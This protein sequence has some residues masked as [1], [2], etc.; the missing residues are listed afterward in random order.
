MQVATLQTND[1][2]KEKLQQTGGKAS[3]PLIQVACCCFCCLSPAFQLL[4]VGRRRTVEN[5]YRLSMKTY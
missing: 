3:H 1:R 2:I 4:C 5:L